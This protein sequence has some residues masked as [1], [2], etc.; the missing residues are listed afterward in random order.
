[1]ILSLDNFRAKSKPIG[2]TG[3]DTKM[4]PANYLIDRTLSVNDFIR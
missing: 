2:N 4:I 3:Y 1:M